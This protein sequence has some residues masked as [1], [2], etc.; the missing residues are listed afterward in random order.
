MCVL[1]HVH[2][3]CVVCVC[4]LI[5]GRCMYVLIS[6]GRPPIPFHSALSTVETTLAD[7][8]CS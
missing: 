2:A 8:F 7:A 4:V 6:R 5:G 1:V 3:V